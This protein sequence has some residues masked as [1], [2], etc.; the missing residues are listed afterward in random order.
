MRDGKSLSA[1]ETCKRI[2][3]VDDALSVG[4][5]DQDTADNRFL[6]YAPDGSSLGVS[7]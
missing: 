7:D 2:T 1:K 6:Q 4:C 3:V 5:W